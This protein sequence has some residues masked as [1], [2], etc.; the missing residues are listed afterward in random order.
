MQNYC[1]FLK[2]SVIIN[3]Q[4]RLKACMLLIHLYLY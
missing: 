2:P 1:N 3:D 4:K